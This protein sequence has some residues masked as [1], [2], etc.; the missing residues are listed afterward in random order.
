MTKVETA[1]QWMENLAND[2]RYGYAWGGWGP[3]DY[4]CGHAIIT[5]WETAGVPVKTAGAAST[6]NMLQVFTSLGFVDVRSSVNLATGAGLQRGDVLLHETDHTAMACGDGKIVHARSS[7]GNTIPGDQNGQEI[8]IQPYFNWSNG[9][10]QHVL[11][12]PE[13]DADQEPEEKE[14][15]EES[16]WIFGKIRDFLHRP[17]SENVF[18]LNTAGFE[19]I[20]IRKGDGMNDPRDIVRV[21][22]LLLRQHGAF[23]DADGEFGYQTEQA[24]KNFQLS[25]NLSADGVV[26]INTWI[27]LILFSVS[28]LNNYGG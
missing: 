14:D 19:V 4:D 24:V 1:T 23:L 28:E 7:E 18:N 17:G 22:Q 25:R 6:H 12:Y 15:P 9:G 20:I 3:W 2:N 26:G 8:R 11:R 16:S 13:T 21:A 5:A 10:W 27:H